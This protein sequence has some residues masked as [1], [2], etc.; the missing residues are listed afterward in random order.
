[1]SLLACRIGMSDEPLVGSRK[2]SILTCLALGYIRMGSCK[3]IVCSLG[4]NYAYKESL[5]GSGTGC[6]VESRSIDLCS[7]ALLEEVSLDLGCV[8]AVVLFDILSLTEKKDSVCC[9]NIDLGTSVVLNCIK[10]SV[11]SDAVTDLDGGLAIADVSDLSESGSCFKS[12]YRRL[13]NYCFGDRCLLHLFDDGREINLLD[14]S[15]VLDEALVFSADDFH[16][17]LLSMPA[18]SRRLVINK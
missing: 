16:K 1:V 17:L 12:C 9:E 8:V 6:I 5:V 7:H 4:K 15:A 10:E 2:E 3:R 11:V 18:L 14:E 13:I